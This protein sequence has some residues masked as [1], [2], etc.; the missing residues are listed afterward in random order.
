MIIVGTIQRQR[1]I[2]RK[3]QYVLFTMIKP[4]KLFPYLCTLTFSILCAVTLS[5][6]QVRRLRTR[7]LD[8][9]FHL[10][11]MF[12]HFISSA[13]QLVRSLCAGSWNRPQIRRRV[14]LT[15]AGGLFFRSRWFF[16]WNPGRR[17]GFHHCQISLQ[18]SGALAAASASPQTSCTLQTRIAPHVSRY[19][20]LAPPLRLSSRRCRVRENKLCCFLMPQ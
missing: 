10:G 12:A 14:L 17:S 2:P 1:L 16:V 4:F 19:I 20:S 7:R 18:T 13:M 8:W 11:G 3:H 5:A 9:D 6:R 15:G